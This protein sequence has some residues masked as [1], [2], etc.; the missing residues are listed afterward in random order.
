MC[1]R[2]SI[3]TRMYLFVCLMYILCVQGSNGTSRDQILH[4]NH[5]TVR[6]ALS[7]CQ[8][9]CTAL[10]TTLFCSKVHINNNCMNETFYRIRKTMMY[11]IYNNYFHEFIRTHYK[12]S[13]LYKGT[14]RNL[15]IMHTKNLIILSD[16]GGSFLRIIINKLET[17]I[18]VYWF[19][20]CS[21]CCCGSI[22]ICLT[23]FAA[24]MNTAEDTANQGKHEHQ[25][26]TSKTNR[27]TH[28]KVSEIIC[29]RNALR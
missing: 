6:Q 16:K 9:T 29:E 14:K 27:E 17:W 23:P 5:L 24:I 22:D 12:L 11:C 10:A 26:G 13:M 19:W 20:S 4:K 21:C 1:G 25:K 7:N 18:L 3:P 28:D 2:T 8:H 15:V